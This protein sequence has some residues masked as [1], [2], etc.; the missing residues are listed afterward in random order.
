MIL[1]EMD[2]ES[3]DDEWAD[4]E[5]GRVEINVDSVHSDDEIDQILFLLVRVSIT[6]QPGDDH[7]P[8]WNDF[9]SICGEDEN[10][11]RESA[12]LEIAESWLV[13]RMMSNLRE[14]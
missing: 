12:A 8:G 3:E 14:E 11:E 7:F 6:E 1:A 10:V 2:S 4:I 9:G 13:K 5:A